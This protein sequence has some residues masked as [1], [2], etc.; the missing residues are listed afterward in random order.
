MPLDFLRK[1]QHAQLPLSVPDSHGIEC[2]AVLEAAGYVK[3]A[4]PKPSKGRDTYG[5]QEPAFLLQITD[6]GRQA[7]S[8][9]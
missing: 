3:A 7:I 1:V 5:H 8:D 4:I 6:L 9:H 2:L